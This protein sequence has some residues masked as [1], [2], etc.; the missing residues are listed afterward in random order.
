MRTLTRTI[1][2]IEYRALRTPLALVDSALIHR[3]PQ[4]S[5]VRRAFDGGVNRLDGLAAALLTPP[6]ESRTESPAGSQEQ[7]GRT[8]APRPD[9]TTAGSSDD[10]SGQESH[11]TTPEDVGAELAEEQEQIVEAI[12]SEEEERKHVGELAEAD[13]QTKLDLAEL[14][15]KHKVL[16]LEEERRMREADA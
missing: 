15:A 8:T 7:S 1:V 5:R 10:A 9:A 12:L 16:E 4:E 6:E 3:L 13:E 11:Q 14:R 2:G